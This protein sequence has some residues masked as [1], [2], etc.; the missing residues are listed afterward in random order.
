MGRGTV[1]RHCTNDQRE[2][3][4]MPRA[5][6]ARAARKE[7]RIRCDLWDD[8]AWRGLTDTAKTTYIQVVTSPELSMCGD[9][10]LSIQRLTLERTNDGPSET[11]AKAD[12]ITG[13]LSDLM[14]TGFVHADYQTHEILVVG[15]VSRNRLGRTWQQL[16]RIS[17]DWQ[18]ISSKAIKQLVVEDVR[19]AVPSVPAE[20]LEKLDEDFVDALRSAWAHQGV[21]YEDLGPNSPP[22]PGDPA[23]RPT[24][25]V[26]F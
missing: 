4:F 12:V 20:W 16:V 3:A 1:D 6:R 14:T 25:E 13:D 19:L 17:H 5:P 22:R 15:Y 21:G 8:P 7:A 10:P 23:L 2:G 11:S 9:C 24:T 18:P 26:A